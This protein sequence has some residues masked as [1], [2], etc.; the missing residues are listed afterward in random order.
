MIGGTLRPG[1]SETLADGEFARFNINFM[2]AAS[3]AIPAALTDAV[4]GSIDEALRTALKAAAKSAS[5]SLQTYLENVTERELTRIV[6]SVAQSAVSAAAGRGLNMAFGDRAS[7]EQ[8]LKTQI[9]QI[10]RTANM[11]A[12]TRAIRDYVKDNRYSPKLSLNWTLG[13]FPT[14]PANPKEKG[15]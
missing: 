12:N 8:H 4:K 3:K 9:S 7:A 11:N 2:D 13:P 14:K 1:Y 5:V 10:K 6:E 15:T